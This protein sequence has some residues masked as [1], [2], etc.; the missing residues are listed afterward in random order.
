MPNYLSEIIKNGED[1]QT[2]FKQNFAKELIET[3][4]TFSNSKGGKI[5]IGVNDAGQI[6]GV[7]ANEETIKDWMTV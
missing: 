1:Q 5:L 4:C 2:E 7:N 6:T 3:V